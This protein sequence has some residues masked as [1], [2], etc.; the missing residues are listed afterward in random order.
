MAA[1]EV[2]V[3][4]SYKVKVRYRATPVG[5]KIAAVEGDTVSVAFDEPQ[6]VTAKGQS[7]VFYNDQ[8]VI[9]FGGVIC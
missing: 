6:R 9:A 1:S 7:A 3:G 4:D 8:G 5:C 2:L